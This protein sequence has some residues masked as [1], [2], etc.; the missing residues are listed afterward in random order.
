MAGESARTLREWVYDAA[1]KLDAAGLF[2]G[3]GT[4]NALDEAVYLL[5]HALKTDFD[6]TGME[7]DAPLLPE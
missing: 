5:S 1:K 2:Y 7:L 3:H 6:F 4:D